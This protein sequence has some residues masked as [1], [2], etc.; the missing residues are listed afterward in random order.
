MFSSYDDRGFKLHLDFDA[1][2]YRKNGAK[3]AG[4]GRRCANCSTQTLIGR[5]GMCEIATIVF[6]IVCVPGGSTED[7]TAGKT[8]VRYQHNRDPLSP[9]CDPVGA[10]TPED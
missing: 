2:S 4:N 10:I 8:H 6:V 1:L 5:D 7:F 3:A 9:Q